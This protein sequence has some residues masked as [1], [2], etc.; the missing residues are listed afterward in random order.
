MKFSI[1]SNSSTIL[2]IRDQ[3]LRLLVFTNG[4][5]QKARARAIPPEIIRN[6][7]V[8]N[9]Q[10]LGQEIRKFIG[11]RSE[12]SHNINVILPGLRTTCRT[13]EAPKM[14]RNLKRRF[15]ERQIPKEMPID[16]REL[17]ISIYTI[18][19]YSA[20][21]KIEQI[22]LIGIPRSLIDRLK[23]ALYL[24]GIKQ[25]SFTIRPF[26]IA[27]LATK[28]DALIFDM[29]NDEFNIIITLKGQPYMVYSK[30]LDSSGAVT[31]TSRDSG[32]LAEIQRSYEYLG[33]FLLKHKD[34]QKLSCY[35]TGASSR[36]ENIKNVIK[37]TYGLQLQL[38]GYEV[39]FPEEVK[40]GVYDSGLG[41]LSL[42]GKKGGFLSR[43]PSI[44]GHIKPQAIHG[45]PTIVEK[46]L[47]RYVTYLPYLLG[48]F[49]LAFVFFIN[50]GQQDIL[51][52][53][54]EEVQRLQA[55]ENAQRMVLLK[56]KKLDTDIRK[57]QTSL[58]GPVNELVNEYKNIDKKSWDYHVSIQYLSDLATDITITSISARDNKLTLAGKTGEMQAA[59][60]YAT[61]LGESP[62]LSGIRI[63]GINALNASSGLA[64][65]GYNFTLVAEISKSNANLAAK[66]LSISLRELLQTSKTL[67]VLKD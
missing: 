62:R 13:I 43:T 8:L 15:L 59:F 21:I 37:N 67:N 47:R 29:E 55:K 61:T 5:L 6:G 48:V 28:E 36:N 45:P 10:A 4:A 51:K 19:Q 39:T 49:L 27:G 46:A 3:E 25:A 33:E 20:A 18:N 42:L 41:L 52:Q 2:E 66:N 54:S 17:Y 31:D 22:L 12:N 50:Q 7:Q 1:S 65:A 30:S 38:P 16:I 53:K 24:A 63:T 60:D 40:C 26:A 58:D 14:S 35:L 23:E 34:V 44:P 32:T 9:I 64:T 57:I 56:S 11:D